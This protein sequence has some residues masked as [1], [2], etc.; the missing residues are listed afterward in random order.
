MSYAKVR[1]TLNGSIQFLSTQIEPWVKQ[2]KCKNAFDLYTYEFTDPDEKARIMGYIHRRDAYI[3]ILNMLESEQTSIAEEESEARIKPIPATRKWEIINT[4]FTRR[5]SEVM[6]NVSI[7]E[8]EILKGFTPQ[9]WRD[10]KLA[11]AEAIQQGTFENV[12][13]MFAALW[14]NSN[15]ESLGEVHVRAESDD[16]RPCDV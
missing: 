6:K 9:T 14:Y 13:P 7:E 8:S 1:E 11:I 16:A 2:Y 12:I 4:A 3:G 15:A 5:A 10:S